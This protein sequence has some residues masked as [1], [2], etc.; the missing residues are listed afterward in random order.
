[1]RSRVLYIILGLSLFYILIVNFSNLRGY[2][3]IPA[4]D[5]VSRDQQLVE[6]ITTMREVVK[7]KAKGSSEEKELYS[8]VTEHGKILAELTIRRFY[9]DQLAMMLMIMTLFLLVAQRLRARQMKMPVSKDQVI[10]DMQVAMDTP[11]EEYIDEWELDR[12]VQEG[13]TSKDAAIHFLK[14]DPMLKCDY[15]GSRLRSTFTG[16]RE[17]IQLV[18]FYKAVPAGAKDL[19]VVLGTYWFPKHATELRCS[20]CG[21]IVQR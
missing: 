4:R 21:K 17:S 11:R 10:R 14:N 18:T 3:T 20:Q 9:L 13:F 8:L 15:C 19:R 5:L 1:M 16:Q 7:G 6:Q 2:R 12:R